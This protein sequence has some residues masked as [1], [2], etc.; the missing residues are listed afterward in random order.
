M[1]STPAAAPTAPAGAAVGLLGGS[2][3]PAH[4]G[5]LHITQMA[6][7]RLGLDRIWWLVSPGNPL[8]PHPPAEMSRRVAAA[9]ALAPR[10]VT[11][12]DIEARLGARY[13]ADTLAALTAL[14]PALRFTWLM[15][16]DNLV[17]FHRW[18]SWRAI[19]EIA[20]IAVLPRPGLVSRA[21][22][23]PAARAFARRR[24]ASQDAA[25]APRAAPPCWVL[26]TGPTSSLS[27]TAIR[28]RGDWP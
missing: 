5:H 16:A 20:P 7:R 22:L 6:F 21:G 15:G 19:F 4:D 28:A 10:R 2:F 8:K 12:S 11:V 13:T 17:Q 3:D 27:S 25:L 26:L 23:S 1:I 14:Y 18:E 9:R 24:L